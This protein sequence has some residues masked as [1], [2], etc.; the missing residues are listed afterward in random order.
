MA[1][2]EGVKPLSRAQQKLIQ[3]QQVL[4][5]LPHS[6]IH[7]QVANER[8][9]GHARR[10]PTM[11]EADPDGSS[12]RS[13]SC[14][15]PQTIAQIEPWRNRTPQVPKHRRESSQDPRGD[16]G[17]GGRIDAK[18][19]IEIPMLPLLARTCSNDFLRDR[20]IEVIHAHPLCLY[21]N[22]AG[23]RDG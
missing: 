6:G 19:G 22:T 17:V 16:E 11:F 13:R 12:S 9:E 8:H 10:W 18:Q 1:E 7:Q 23:G 4:K 20:I 2:A 21:S 3:S 15:D 14:S 5:E